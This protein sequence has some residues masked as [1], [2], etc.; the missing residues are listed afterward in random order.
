MEIIHL[1][2]H[3]GSAAGVRRDGSSRLHHLHSRPGPAPS[4]S[5]PLAGR[6]PPRPCVWAGSCSRS[7][8]PLW[9]A[10]KSAGKGA[11]VYSDTAGRSPNLDEHNGVHIE[12]HVDVQI[13]REGKIGS[14]CSSTC[15]SLCTSMCTLSQKPENISYFM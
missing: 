2:R 13:E 1:T 11:S 4:S 9:L 15:T 6:R 3:H 12:V 7:A 8:L 14:N 5:P 10:S